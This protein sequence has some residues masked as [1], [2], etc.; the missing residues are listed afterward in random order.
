M[1]Y[2]QAKRSRTWRLRLGER[3]VLIL[4][5]DLIAALI[6]LLG[7][8]Y[9]WAAGD[10]WLGRLSIE[11]LQQRPQAWFYLLPV[12]WVFMMVELYDVHRAASWRATLRSILIAALF[13]SGIYLLIYFSSAPF[14]LPR[15]GVAGFI[16]LVSVFTLIWRMIYIRVFTAPQ[17]MRRVLLVGAGST[18]QGL[19]EAINDLWPPPFHLLGV[20]DDDPQ[21][22]GTE[23]A[24]IKVIDN[25]DR[26][27]EIVME[28]E[29][30]DILVAI[31]GRMQNSTFRALLDAQE[32]GVEITRMPVAYEELLGRV[33]IHHLEADWILRSFVDETRVSG[34]YEIVKRL[35]DIAGGLIGV[36]IL[37]A[38]TPIVSLLILLESGWPVIFS[39]MR[40]GKGGRQYRIL[41]FRTLHKPKGDGEKRSPINEDE[42]RITKVGR[43][44]R[45]THL[46]EWPQFINV[47]RGEMSLVGPRPEQPSLVDRWQESI[48][49][50]RARLLIKPGIAGWAQVNFGYASTIE[51]TATKLEYDLYYIKNRNMIMD[52]VVILRTFGTMFGFRG[53]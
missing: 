41:K 33:P 40:V 15:R 50:Y 31:S 30:T 44:L 6:A 13:G 1:T 3:R 21:K 12:F 53:R 16:V 38:I 19:L 11:F 34:I 51:E 25:S 52:I 29:I 22:V 46:D 7:A 32:L 48:P 36:L 5:G 42:T 45:K 27:L 18:G 4:I 17:F 24:G 9:F 20:I 43:F 35:V 26:L 28:N 39:Q 37:I 47:L 8:L 14:S 23:I 10:Q 49:F 2:K